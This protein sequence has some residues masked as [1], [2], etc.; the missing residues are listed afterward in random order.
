MKIEGPKL[1]DVNTESNYATTKDIETKLANYATTEYVNNAIQNVSSGSIDES[2]FVKQ[3]TV[4]SGSESSIPTIT[5]EYY[6]MYRGHDGFRSTLL[7]RFH[8][9]NPTLTR[10]AIGDRYQRDKKGYINPNDPIPKENRVKFEFCNDIWVDGNI[11]CSGVVSNS[12]TTILHQCPI[13]G[14]IKDFS[15]GC[16]IFQTG[17]VFKNNGDYTFS[18]TTMKDSS[19]CIPSVKILGTWREFIG[20]CTEVDTEHNLIRFASH[21]DY[22]FR[23]DDEKLY[24]VGD[25]LLYNGIIVGED[26]TITAKIRRMTVGIITGIIGEG[27]VAVFKS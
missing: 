25:E 17:K 22:L 10:V 5:H 7:Q 21:G 11:K 13:E 1:Y 23:V 20:I 8:F 4:I 18:E 16:P 12:S 9:N 26:V 27:L 6:F 24:Q 19:D 15:I 14:N 3:A 2:K